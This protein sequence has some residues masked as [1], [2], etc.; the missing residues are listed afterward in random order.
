MASGEWLFPIYLLF[1]L[2][3]IYALW[4]GKQILSLWV[5]YIEIAKEIWRKRNATPKK[6]E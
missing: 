5:K 2:A 4:K 6:K 3:L 1:L